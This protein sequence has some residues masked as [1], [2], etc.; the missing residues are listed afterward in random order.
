MATTTEEILNNGK[1]RGV[2]RM[3]PHT[4]HMNGKPREGAAPA[5]STATTQAPTP[6]DMLASARKAMTEAPAP[7]PKASTPQVPTKMSY[8]EM[9]DKWFQKRE[10]DLEAEAKREKRN[11]VFGAISDGISAL[12]NIYG[13]Y[14]GAKS[15]YDPSQSLSAKAKER[16]DKIMSD[17][18][19]LRRGWFESYM[20]ARSMDEAAEQAKAA[21]ARAEENDRYA[22]EQAERQWTYNVAKD[23]W[24]ADF[25]RDQQEHKE[26]TDN[27]K[28]DFKEDELA[29]KKERDEANRRQKKEQD[30]RRNAQ[31]DKELHIAED[32]ANNAANKGGKAGMVK[33][34]TTQE[35]KDIVTGATN[36]RR[37]ERYVS[38][39]DAPKAK[40]QPK[41]PSSGIGN[42][43]K[44]RGK[45]SANDI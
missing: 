41:A 13:T 2:G 20:R 34:V 8:A 24:L 44:L 23:N 29:Y 42:A 11:R 21:A 15:V 45:E 22:R 32:K 12:S 31:R 10:A 43:D 36:T 28:Q 6:Q 37:E 38:D 30:S 16:Y 19:A 39:H 1:G 33:V 17:R 7:A 40:E 27:R 9:T 5:P 18:D 35:T 26:E 14:H 3:V 4:P 25:K